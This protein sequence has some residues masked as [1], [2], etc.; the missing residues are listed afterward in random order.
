[1]SFVFGGRPGR[2]DPELK[3]AAQRRREAFARDIGDEYGRAFAHEPPRGRR[4]WTSLV[5]LGV[6]LFAGFGLIPLLRGSAGGLVAQQCDRPAVGTS[7]GVVAPGGRAAW[8]VAGP[9]AGEYVVAV[10][11]GGVAVDGSGTVTAKSGRLLSGPFR[12]DGCR[13]AQTLFD[14]PTDRGTHEITL[15]RRTTGS[16]A[17][18]ADAALK[19][20]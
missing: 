17:A 10:D 12:L 8:Q 16:F 20:G 1:V 4:R 11:S 6:V 9:D 5:G 18:V 2:Q 19:V 7:A 13:S 14:A 3:R 15:F